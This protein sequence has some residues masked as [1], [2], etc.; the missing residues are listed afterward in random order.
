MTERG[1]RSIHH[2]P[3]F[4]LPGYWL[5][6][7]FI[8]Q[9][10]GVEGVRHFNLSRFFLI[11]NQNIILPQ[12]TNTQIQELTI[13]FRLPHYLLVSNIH[14]QFGSSACSPHHDR[15]GSLK[16]SLIVIKFDVTGPIDMRPLNSQT[17]PRNGAKKLGK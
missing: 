4:S 7:L 13:L 9:F 14:L 11:S 5:F 16:Y 8:S 3:T 2:T 10:K 6:R 15:T 12:Y 1:S 17:R